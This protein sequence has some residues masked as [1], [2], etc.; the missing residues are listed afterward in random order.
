MKYKKI[1]PK[2]TGFI[3]IKRQISNIDN[4][5]DFV[6]AKKFLEGKK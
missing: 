5:E 3:E 2:K 1:L 4:M 6:E